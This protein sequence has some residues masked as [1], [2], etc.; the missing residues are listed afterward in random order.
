MCISGSRAYMPQLAQFKP[1]NFQFSQIKPFRRHLKPIHSHSPARS[2]VK[3]QYFLVQ[4]Y[5]TQL[6]RKTT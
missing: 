3:F 5:I 2:K 1:H 4:E 6:H